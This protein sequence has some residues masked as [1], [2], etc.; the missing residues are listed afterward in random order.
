M[1]ADPEEMGFLQVYLDLQ[2]TMVVE[3]EDSVSAKV[4]DRQA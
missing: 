1:Q 3:A 2:L 4:V